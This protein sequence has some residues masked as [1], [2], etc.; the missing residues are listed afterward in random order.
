ML[1]ISPGDRESAG[2]L[3]DPWRGVFEN[4][5]NRAQELEGKAF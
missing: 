2:Q 1:V 4:A 5:I 3:I